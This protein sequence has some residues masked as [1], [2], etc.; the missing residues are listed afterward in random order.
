MEGVAK[1]QIMR[2]AAHWVRVTLWMVL[3]L[4]SAARALASCH[5]SSLGSEKFIL[6]RPL[7]Q[8]HEFAKWVLRVNRRL[9]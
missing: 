9:G 2:A 8:W 4:P 3:S 7:T 6:E 5:S 1:T